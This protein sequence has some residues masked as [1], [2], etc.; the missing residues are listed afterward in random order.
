MGFNY[1]FLICLEHLARTCHLA[2]GSSLRVGG[3]L[4]PP[5]AVLWNSFCFPSGPSRSQEACIS[6]SSLGL[7]ALTLP[8]VPSG[9]VLGC[10]P[11]VSG[12]LLLH[13]RLPPCCRTRFENHVSETW[14][15]TR[16][17]SP[18]PRRLEGSDAA[19]PAEGCTLVWVRAGD[20]SSTTF[21]SAQPSDA[22]SS[23]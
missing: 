8:P 13:S 12:S 3:H 2:P 23:A 1:S 10:T 11:G 19:A 9:L 5:G 17:L 21:I 7:A 22:E 20:P 18:A 14:P 4:S 6:P 16:L 15:W